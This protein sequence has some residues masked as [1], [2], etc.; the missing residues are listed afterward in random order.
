MVAQAMPARANMAFIRRDGSLVAKEGRHAEGHR[1]HDDTG[2]DGLFPAHLGGNHAHR[3]VGNNG[4]RLG[5]D[6]G[7][8]IVLM[9]DIAGIDGVFASDGIIAEEPQNDGQK[10][11]DHG[12]LLLRG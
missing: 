12:L 3:Q 2:P 8:V 5:D 10:N 11:E 4:R 1:Q 6:E 7:K 9:E